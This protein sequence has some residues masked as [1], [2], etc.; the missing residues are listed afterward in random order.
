MRKIFFVIF[1][2]I[3]FVSC[4]DDDSYSY[5]Y[6]LLAVEDAE[7]PEEFVYGEIYELRVKYKVPDD[8][9]VASEILYEYDGPAR[10]IAVLSLV[11]DKDL[12]EPLDLEDYLSVRVHALQTSPY[13]FR[14]WQGEDENG[15]PI[16]L[17]KEVPVLM[18]KDLSADEF[19]TTHTKM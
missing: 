12:C 19:E 15:D 9:Y 1:A 8:C 14:F 6:E 17:V 16:Y 18:Q 2:V 11:L 4:S 3:T 5:H 10:N 13:I 7:V